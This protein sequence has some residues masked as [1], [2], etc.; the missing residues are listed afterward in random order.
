MK[1]FQKILLA[2]AASFS[3]FSCKH[4]TVVTAITA[5]GQVQLSDGTSQSIPGYADTATTILYVVR[6]AEKLKNEGDDP[7]LTDAGK[8]RAKRLL[9]IFEKAYIN[10]LVISNKK[11][12]R[13]TLADVKARLDPPV[14]TVPGD[15]LPSWLN[16]ELFQSYKGKKLLIAHHSNTIPQMLNW[17]MKPGHFTDIADEDYGNF[18]IVSTRGQG[19]TEVMSLRY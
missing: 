12:T 13:E 19:Q 8:A 17:L 5:D 16:I 9:T 18:Y 11:R 14:E 10:R 2:A 4:E 1:F 3:L 15:I 7:G 6:H